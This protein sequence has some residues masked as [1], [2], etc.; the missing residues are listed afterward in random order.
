MI[1][2]K[3]KDIDGSEV[4]TEYTNYSVIAWIFDKRCNDN[5]RIVTYDT[6][7]YDD[8]IQWISKLKKCYGDSVEL[9]NRVDNN[10]EYIELQK[11]QILYP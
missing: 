7:N 6:E 11:E 1:T 10:V 5:C 8:A 2:V 3:G 9:H 4:I